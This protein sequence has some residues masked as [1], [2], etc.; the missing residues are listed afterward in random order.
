MTKLSDYLLQG[1]IM[2]KQAR[3]KV[4]VNLDS[5]ESRKKGSI[6]TILLK[7]Q[8]GTFHAEDND[9][10]CKLTCDEFEYLDS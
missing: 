2:H 4:D 5:G 1:K 10:A 3:L 8:D 9:F 6:I 7:N